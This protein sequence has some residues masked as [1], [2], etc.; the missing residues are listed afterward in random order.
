MQALLAKFNDILLRVFFC[1]QEK[2][3]FY[4]TLS[5]RIHNQN[6]DFYY[7]FYNG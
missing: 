4:T 6:T 5:Q 2:H 7:H 1:S 3:N